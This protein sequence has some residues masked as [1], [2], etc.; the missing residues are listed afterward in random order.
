MPGSQKEHGAEQCKITVHRD[1]AHHRLKAKMKTVPKSL[2]K[3]LS[4]AL[5]VWTNKK[6]HKS[7]HTK[8]PQQG[9]IRT[10]GVYVFFPAHMYLFVS[11]SPLSPRGILAA[12][13]RPCSPANKKPNASSGVR[14]APRPRPPGPAGSGCASSRPGLCDGHPAQAPGPGRA[15]SRITHPQTMATAA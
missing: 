13:G 10:V 2:E 3:K 5:K 12:P 9:C 4:L 6:V 8:C 11:L 15:S 14:A 7:V 1:H